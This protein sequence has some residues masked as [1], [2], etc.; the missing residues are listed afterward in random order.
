[1]K[2]EPEPLPLTDLSNE[3][4]NAYIAETLD[5]YEDLV[6]DHR[7]LWRT[8]LQLSPTE[9]LANAPLMTKVDDAMRERQAELRELFEY[10]H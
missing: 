6:L 1:M 10:V 5:M 2:H 4:F 8:F 9:R 3:Q 7:A